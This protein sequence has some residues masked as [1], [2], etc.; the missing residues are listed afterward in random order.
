MSDS[1]DQQFLVLQQRFVKNLAERKLR[2]NSFYAQL[3]SLNEKSKSLEV[4]VSLHREVHNLTGAAGCYQFVDLAK[5][6]RKLED[7]LWEPLRKDSQVLITS[8][9]LETLLSNLATL[10]AFIEQ[11]LEEQTKA[12]C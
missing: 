11:L 6:A 10:V 5:E 12:D 1:F 8:K 9:W 3:L 2:I 4:L 7:L